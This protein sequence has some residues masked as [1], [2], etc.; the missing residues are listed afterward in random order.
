MNIVA[1][2]DPYELNPVRFSRVSPEYLGSWIFMYMSVLS[3]DCLSVC[4]L[5][6]GGTFIPGVLKLSLEIED[7]GDNHKKGSVQLPL[8]EVRRDVLENIDLYIYE[9]N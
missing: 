6:D 3:S 2:A 4:L 1:A 8:Y 5:F 9:M 7:V